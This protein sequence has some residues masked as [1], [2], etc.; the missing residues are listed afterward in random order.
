MNLAFDAHPGLAAH[1]EGADAL[2]AVDLVAGE[3]HQVDL[4]A[5]DVEVHLAGGLR[6][7][8]VEDDA[9]LMADR[10]DRLEVLNDADLVVDRH[11]GDED[12]VGTDGR[13]EGVH[14]DEAVLLDVE[15]GHLVALAFKMAHRVEH[16]LVLGLHRDEVT[17]LVLVEVRGALDG[18]I[19]ALRCAGRPDDL[20]GIGA[21]EGGNVTAG[22]FNGLL[23]LPA[24]AVAVAG[25]V[26]ELLVEIRNHLVDHA[27]VA[28]RRRG[29]VKVN[30]Q[31]HHESF[32]G[33]DRRC[34]RCL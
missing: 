17:A 19:V 10:A 22:L 18:E 8:A 16:G 14:V 24:V 6:G 2:R 1:V 31:L 15:V 23:G 7:V 12:R 5:V 34:R 20:A 11:H 28:G 13:T 21:N 26:A 30:G 33:T 9:V 27:G 29:V 32:L 4:E 3:A 25:G